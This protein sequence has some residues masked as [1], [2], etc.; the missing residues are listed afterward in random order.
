MQPKNYILVLLL[1]LAYLSNVKGQDAAFSQ[2]YANPLY[3]NPA[4]AGAKLCPRLTLN[5]R[6]QWPNIKNG[7]VTYSATWD[8]NY[9]A[10]SGGLG[11][12]V[13]S[14]VGG[15]GIYNT[16]NG[17]AVYSYR[18]QAS[19]TLVLNAAFQAGYM[20]YRI[21][22]DK[23]VFGDQININTGIHE[24]SAESRP[25]KPNVGNF[26]LSAGFLA[27]Y[28]ESV[29]FGAVVNHLSQP[30]MSFYDGNSNPL[31]MKITVHAGAIFD[32]VQGMDGEDLRNFSL[33]PNVVYMQQGKFHQLNLGMSVNMFPFV[34][35]LWLRHNFEN[36]DAMIVLLGFQQKQ[37]KI[38]YSF[39][40]TI[41]KLSTQG[42]GAHEISIA[43][44]FNNF[45]KKS[46]YTEFKGPSF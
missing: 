1:V 26:D 3:L 18:L 5:Y 38:G 12:I 37:Y 4:L 10:I 22:W 11:F 30:N 14:T 19:R 25:G 2:F 23:F 13:N 39:D 24:Q 15:G 7:Y 45:H 41:S 32:F 33:S 40:Y 16:F 20:Q 31:D 9:N 36:P 46:R 43:W 21:N 17:S 28:K 6:D 35:G 42:G 27:G 44:L 34:G 8:N 29:Y